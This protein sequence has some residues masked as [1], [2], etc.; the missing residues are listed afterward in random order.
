MSILASKANNIQQ[1]ACPC[2]S[3]QGYADCCAPL[4]RGMTEAQTAQQLMRSRYCAYV[5]KLEDY[6]LQTWAVRTRPVEI[7]FDENLHWQKLTILQTQKGRAKD[8]K[9]SVTFCAEFEQAGQHFRMTEK[10]RFE[11]NPQGHWVYVDGAF[12]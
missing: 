7:A 8:K 5:F 2:G 6:L 11:R 12:Y 10:S 9:G 1:L 3:T 4:H